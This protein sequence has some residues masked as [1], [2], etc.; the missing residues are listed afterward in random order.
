MWNEYSDSVKSESHARVECFNSK[1]FRRSS[2]SGSVKTLNTPTEYWG[3]ICAEKKCKIGLCGPTPIQCI[4][5]CFLMGSMVVQSGLSPPFTSLLDS[6]M[7]T[8]SI[9]LG[10]T[11]MQKYKT[12]L[13]NYLENVWIDEDWITTELRSKRYPSDVIT[14]LQGEFIALQIYR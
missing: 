8:R 12:I 9:Q 13:Q 14:D 6:E 1:T 2:L 4:S 10:V 11:M 7:I 5:L 3:G